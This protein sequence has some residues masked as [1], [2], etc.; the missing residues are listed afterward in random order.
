MCV[1][2]AFQAYPRLILT[3][4]AQLSAPDYRQ[5]EAAAPRVDGNSCEGGAGPRT[6]PLLLNSLRGAGMG[7]EAPH[8]VLSCPA[9]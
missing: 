3:R 5:E 6:L 1:L 8:M 2:S 9:V 7:A 4:L